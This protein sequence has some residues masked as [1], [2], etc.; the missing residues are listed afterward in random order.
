[1][2]GKKK[3][4]NRLGL[5]ANV[6]EERGDRVPVF[7]GVGRR[8]AGCQPSEKGE[9][10]Y[11]CSAGKRPRMEPLF[12]GKKGERKAVECEGPVAF[13][14]EEKEK[15]ARVPKR[16]GGEKKA[17]LLRTRKEEGISRKKVLDLLPLKKR[18]KQQ[19]S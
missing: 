4:G 6:G 16:E 9:M 12:K 1:L 15:V 18:S 17:R 2:R 14:E 11:S 8:S 3:K 7:A 19:L 13:G 10:A 5:P